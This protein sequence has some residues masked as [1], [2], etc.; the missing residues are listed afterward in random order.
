M[1]HASVEDDDYMGYRIP[2]GALIIANL[3]LLLSP[4]FEAHSIC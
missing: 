2:K 3:W 1:P 4:C